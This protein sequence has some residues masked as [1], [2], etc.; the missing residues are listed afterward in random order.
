LPETTTTTKPAATETAAEKQA[1]PQ[2]S[3]ETKPEPEKKGK[4]ERTLLT[5]DEQVVAIEAALASVPSAAIV[6]ALW[7]L[8]T[9]FFRSGM[10]KH[11]GSP[12]GCF[13]ILMYGHELGL[14][15]MQAMSNIYVIEGK[16]AMSSQ[17]MQS[18]AESRGVK[19]KMLKYT[20]EE[21]RLELQYG[22]KEAEEFSFTKADVQRAGLS[23][24][25]GAAH[26]KYPRAMLH[27]RALSEGL[28]MYA[29]GVLLQSYTFDELTDGRASDLEGFLELP[30]FTGDEPSGGGNG[31]AKPANGKTAAVAADLKKQ[32]D[33]IPPAAAPEDD[34]TKIRRLSTPGEKMTALMKFTKEQLL[35]WANDLLLEVF[36]D[37]LTKADRFLHTLVQNEVISHVD[38]E[39]NLKPSLGRIICDVWALQDKAVKP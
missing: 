34:L 1:Q 7:K 4:P 23:Q 27:W 24:K 8:A 25:A 35:R 21:C 6:N 37:D 36:E 12:A 30:D 28:R 19:I 39:S 38:L 3:T 14:K 2:E 17:L 11:A 16:P 18:I 15:P 5:E 31:A 20:E 10:F 9:A 32:A 33:T 26:T 22:D 29:P 13:V